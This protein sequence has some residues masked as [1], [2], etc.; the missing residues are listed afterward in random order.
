[1][2]QEHISKYIKSVFEPALDKA[3]PPEEIAFKNAIKDF[4]FDFLLS[5]QLFMAT[6]AADLSSELA[7][8]DYVEQVM[9]QLGATLEQ[10]MER[11]PEFRNEKY[12]NLL[13]SFFSMVQFIQFKLPGLNEEQKV[14]SAMIQ[15]EIL[16][17]RYLTTTNEKAERLLGKHIAYLE[18]KVVKNISDKTAL[19]NSNFDEQKKAFENLG[20]EIDQKITTAIS[21]VEDKQRKSSGRELP[22]LFPKALEISGLKERAFRAKLAKGDVPHFKRDGRLQ[23]FESELIERLKEGK[24]KTAAEKSQEVEK[25]LRKVNSK[26]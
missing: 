18:S 2:S 7:I 25:H 1:M 10:M 26:K 21:K 23:F 20:G 5:P 24:V 17:E 13:V 6:D 8:S 4:L 15:K 9:K 22:I 3:I 19:T 16:A 11:H 14:Q 12:V